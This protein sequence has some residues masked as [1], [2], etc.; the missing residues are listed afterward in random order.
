VE[1]WWP[2][3]PLW[4]LLKAQ[5]WQESRL[6]PTARSRVGAEGIAQ[7]MP[8]TWQDAIKALGWPRTLSRRD[9]AYAIEGGAWYM[10]KLRGGWKNRSPA[11]SHDLALA[12]Y[13]AGVGNILKAQKYCGGARLWPQIAPCLQQATGARNAHETTSYVARIHR[14]HRAMGAEK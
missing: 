11:D 10:R 5:Y 3:F 9:A 13:N 12:S 6:D 4:R 2:D 7:F 14:W 8:G 1:K